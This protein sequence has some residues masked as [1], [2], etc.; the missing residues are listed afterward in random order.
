MPKKMVLCAIVAF[1][2]AV[3]AHAYDVPSIEAFFGASN[4][5]ATTGNGRLTAAVSPE[6]G[7][8]VL[9]WPSPSYY[10]HLAYIATN[11]LDARDQHRAGVLDRMGAYGG[12]VV[13]G[14]GGERTV[15]WFVGEEWTADV[16]YTAVDSLVVQTT[17]SHPE[18]PVE[19]A[20]RDFVTVDQDAL[21]RTYDVEVDADA[22]IESVWLLSYSNLSP[23]QTKLQ[24]MPIADFAFEQHQ[25]FIAVWDRASESVIHFHPAGNGTMESPLGIARLRDNMKKEFGPIGALLSGT[26]VD[27]G[28]LDAEVA[29]ID[30][31]YESGVYVAHAAVPAADQFQVGQDAMDVCGQIGQLADNI[32]ER[33]EQGVNPGFTIPAGVVGVLECGTFDPVATPADENG[34][35]HRPQDALSDAEDG[36]LSG[37]RVAAAQ[38]NTVL[39]V[40]VTLQSGS[41]SASVVY[42]FGHTH[43]EAV[44][45]L[46]SVRSRD[47]A[48]LQ[49][50]VETDSADWASD[51]VI[52]ESLSTAHQKLRK[53][54]S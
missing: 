30:E 20:Q 53:R 34:W 36:E 17:Y 13:E 41:G 51:L 10:D 11:D 48:S 42:A 16:T 43:G 44:S 8:S 24:Q 50:E 19:V 40:P 28:E 27:G 47:V 45:V 4:I 38:A 3:P 54:R 29:A 49:G 9:S 26:T 22:Q 33:L 5:V 12:I 1:L 39:R 23:S 25:D 18:I 21:V 7:L 15:S 31:N 6:G 2:F 46:D 35:Q 32:T 14:Q 52:P 37:S